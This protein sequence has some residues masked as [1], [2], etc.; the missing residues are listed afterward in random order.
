MSLTPDLAAPPRDEQSRRRLRHAKK[1]ARSSGVYVQGLLNGLILG[2][3]INFGNMGRASGLPEGYSAGYGDHF[4]LSPVGLHWADE[5]RFAGDWFMEA[6]PQPHWFFDGLTFIGS[7]TGTL[8]LT[9]LLFWITG[10]AAFGLAAA[11]LSREWATKTPWLFGITTTVVAALTP[12]LAVGTG[13]SMISMALPAVVSANLVFLFMAAALTGRTKWMLG[14]ALATAV[15]HVQQGA[16]VVILLAVLSACQFISSRK[17]PRSTL[18]SLAAAACVVAAALAARPVAANGDDFIEIC[19]TIIPYHCA[20]QQWTT[21]TV[22][23]SITVIVLAL[24]TVLY[25]NSGDRLVWSAVVGLPMAG[26][27]LGLLANVMSVPFFGTA[28]QSLNVYRLGAL[29]LPFAVMGMLLPLFRLSRKDAASAALVLVL[30]WIYLLAGAWQLERPLSTGLI[31]SYMV[32]MLAPFVARMT[33]PGVKVRLERISALAL[34]LLLVGN[35]LFAGKITPRLLETGFMAGSETMEW[36][37]AVEKAVPTGE[38]LLASPRSRY[39]RATTY[40]GVVA[41]CKNIPYGGE[42]WTQWQERIED[43]GGREQCMPGVPDRAAYFDSLTPE[44]LDRTAD[45]YGIRYAVLEA[46]QADVLPGL[47]ELGW[48]VELEPVNSVNNLL[49]SKAD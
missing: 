20:A 30:S 34:I 24:C 13:T 12:W 25:R 44:E 46:A 9:Y 17:V 23:S 6:A 16:V 38:S 42:A 45:K 10:L 32:L 11:F 14:A 7:A 15:V 5:S 19:N 47:E 2:M 29:V 36:G 3:L 21:S 48:R 37:Q 31:G 18:L 41:D 39:V 27:L 4:V 40:R 33:Y 49:L 22:V 8:P 43:L 35:A 28:A 1:P 26:L